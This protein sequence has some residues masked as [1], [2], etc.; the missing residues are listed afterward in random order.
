MIGPEYFPP[1]KDAPAPVAGAYYLVWVPNW[2]NSGYAV[3]VYDGP[4]SGGHRFVCD[5]TGQDMD[6]NDIYGWIKLEQ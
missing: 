1:R 5:A 2:S 3:A 6:I 4:S